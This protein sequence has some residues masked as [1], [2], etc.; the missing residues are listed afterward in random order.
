MVHKRISA[1]RAAFRGLGLLFITGIHIKI[2]LAIALLVLA[3]GCYFQISTIEWIAQILC[4]ALVLSM[5]GVNTVIEKLADFIQPEQDPKIR[6]I[7]DLS[8]GVV[9]FASI[10]AAV[11][12]ILIYGPRLF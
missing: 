7:K 4:I 9:L 10:L 5:E 3:A 12:G 8:A 1:F 6:D 2:Q 11:V